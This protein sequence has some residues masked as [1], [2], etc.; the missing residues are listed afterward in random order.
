MVILDSTRPLLKT[1]IGTDPGQGKKAVWKTKATR[2]M[3]LDSL[4][5]MRPLAV[6]HRELGGFRVHH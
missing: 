1:G 2:Q 5:G 6:E 4:E 3:I